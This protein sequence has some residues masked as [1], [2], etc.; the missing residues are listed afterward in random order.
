MSDNSIKGQLELGINRV[1]EKDRNY[2][3]GGRS[4]YFFDFD[5]NI[6]F[7][8]TSLVIFHKKTGE[9]L[10]LSSSDWTLYHSKI[11]TEGQYKDFEI[12]HDD[13]TGSFRYFRDLNPN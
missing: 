6:A 10:F 1:P 7:L 8:T 4:F 13:K 12:R 11:G 5:D 3:L 2:H 9:E